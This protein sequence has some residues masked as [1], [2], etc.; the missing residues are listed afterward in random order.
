M[1]KF[2]YLLCCLVLLILPAQAWAANSCTVYFDDRELALAW[3]GDGHTYLPM[4]VVFEQCGAVVE[5]EYGTQTI[6]AVRPDG[7]VL[8]MQIGRNTAVLEH[9]GQR[10]ELV[11]DATPYVYQGKT[12]VPV[13]FVAEAM[14]C[15]VDWRD[16]AVYIEPQFAL[17]NGEEQLVDD[18]I[19]NKQGIRYFVDYADGSLYEFESRQGT[20]R[21]LLDWPLDKHELGADACRLYL[22][23]DKTAND[24][25]LFTAELYDGRMALVA[26][27]YSH[28]YAW[29]DKN[30]PTNHVVTEI[31]AEPLLLEDGVIWLAADGYL[32]RVDDASGEVQRYDWQYADDYDQPVW[33]DGSLVLL[34][35]G[36]SNGVNYGTRWVLLDIADG[37]VRILTHELLSDENRL[38]LE[39]HP[40]VAN[41]LTLAH[42]EDM[43]NFW[44]LLDNPYTMD[45]A[46]HLCFWEERDGVLIF[47]L[48][49]ANLY[50]ENMNWPYIDIKVPLN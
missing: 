23:L 45:A 8:T 7:A 50:D 46:P 42:Y 31:N 16:G 29:V 9:N 47:R 30:D 15:Q 43:E 25:Y 21:H 11:M 28:Y 39:Q 35:N 12:C 38:R 41:I 26:N 5:W 20:V 33:A 40:D 44:G 6:S 22:W 19:D 34:S 49:A 4:R 1:R 32:A 36:S 37:G 27:A 14:L 18:F 3:Q 17:S 48:Y 10:Q 24:N 13:R 2:W